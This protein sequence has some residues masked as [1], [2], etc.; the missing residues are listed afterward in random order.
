MFFPKACYLRQARGEIIVKKRATVVYG[1][2]QDTGAQLCRAPTPDLSL[3]PPPLHTHKLSTSLLLSLPRPVTSP[4]S[5]HP[6]TLS[7]PT[8]P[9]APHLDAELD[10]ERGVGHEALAEAWGTRGKWWDDK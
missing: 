8:P 2:T 6:R 9:R 1:M 7:A 3:T 10:Q 4:A 5:P